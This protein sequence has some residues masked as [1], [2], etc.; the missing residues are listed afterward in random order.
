MR[1]AFNN[2]G[3]NFRM[4]LGLNPGSIMNFYQLRALFGQG[5]G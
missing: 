1:K 3:I 4:V 5:K 2:R